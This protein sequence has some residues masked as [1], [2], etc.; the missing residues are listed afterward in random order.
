MLTLEIGTTEFFDE[1]TN[2]FSTIEGMFIDFEHSLASISEWESKWQKP[3]LGS[4]QKT[5]EQLLSYLKI[6][7]LTPN[8]PDEVYNR[9]T[10]EHISKIN[11]Y[12]NS[13]E[14]AT[15]FSEAETKH[16]SPKRKLGQPEVTSELV[17]YWMVA[18]NIPFEAQ[19]WHF[20]RLMTLIRICNLKNEAQKNQDAKSMASQRRA[21]NEARRKK[22][23]TTG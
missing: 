1:L 22:H 17:Y 7:T 14:S 3:F 5:G 11:A 21:L 9:L 16:T 23:N 6:M 12:I 10:P 15:Y 18:Y 4:E 20:N 13:P 8:V 19:Y 2:K